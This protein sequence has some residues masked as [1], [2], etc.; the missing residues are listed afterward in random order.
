MFVQATS[1]AHGEEE[2]WIN[3]AAGWLWKEGQAKRGLGLDLQCLAAGCCLSGG[4]ILGVF[5]AL[6]WLT[7]IFPQSYN[8][9]FPAS[10]YAIVVGSSR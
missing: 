4:T 5:P 1:G 9:A 6:L 7:L 2:V 3:S 10:T 8:P